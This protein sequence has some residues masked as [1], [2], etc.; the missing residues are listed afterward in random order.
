MDERTLD[1]V[2][3][4]LVGTLANRDPVAVAGN[5]GFVGLASP[6]LARSLGGRDSQ[7]AIALSAWVGA[8][9]VLLADTLARL[10]PLELPC[11]L[12]TAPLGAPY[13][14][15]LLSRKREW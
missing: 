1:E 3:G 7:S 12:V 11:G 6:H 10:A 14:L 2:R 5:V 8:G 15:F 4:W 13:F 9:L